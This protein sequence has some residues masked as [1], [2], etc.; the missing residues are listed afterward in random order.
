[1][2]VDAWVI[3]TVDHLRTQLVAG[4]HVP[5]GAGKAKFYIDI[6]PGGHPPAIC[7][8]YYIAVDEAGTTNKLVDSGLSEIYRMDIWISKRTGQFAADRYGDMYRNNA[9]SLRLLERAVIVAI[10]NN[11]TLRV[12]VN[13]ELSA[14]D[15]DEGDVCLNPMWFV[16]RDPTRFAGPDWAGSQKDQDTFLVRQLHFAGG[17]R[18]QAMD[19]AG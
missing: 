3:A 11:H 14:P 5:G 18:N 9:R 6:Q 15:A 1:M 12:A 16:S 10:H 17:R 8:E 19:I 13:T 7:G 2:S 4:S